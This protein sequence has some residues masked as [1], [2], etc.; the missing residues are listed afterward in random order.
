[1]TVVDL[2]S[3]RLLLLGGIKGEFCPTNFLIPLKISRKTNAN[4]MKIIEFHIKYLTE[5]LTNFSLKKRCRN[6]TVD[7]ESECWNIFV[8]QCTNKL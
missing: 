3:S 1:M 5:M 6:L 7:S 4:I 8:S 2:F